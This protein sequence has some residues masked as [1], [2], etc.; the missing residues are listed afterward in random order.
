MSRTGHAVYRRHRAHLKRREDT[1]WVCGGYISPD[2]T[3]PHPMSWSADH[4]VP[5]KAGG[6][7]NGQLRAA[8]LIHNQQR[9][10]KTKPVARHSRTW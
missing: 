1:C 7:N 8:H 6:H 10:P 9:N 2:L 5:I 4:V 3:F